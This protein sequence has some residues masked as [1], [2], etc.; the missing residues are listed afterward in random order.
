MTQINYLSGFLFQSSP[1]LIQVMDTRFDI[2]RGK[3]TFV[4]HLITGMS[5]NADATF[6][7]VYFGDD[8][9]VFLNQILHSN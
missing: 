1:M 5:D 8:S 4:N 2:L 3:M 9:L 6:V 7:I